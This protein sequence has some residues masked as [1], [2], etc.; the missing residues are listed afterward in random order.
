MSNHPKLK[1]GGKKMERAKIVEWVQKLMTKAADPAATEAERDSIQ[2]KTEQLMAKYKVSMMEATTP[3]KIK[4]HKMTREDVKFVVPGRSFWGFSLAASI[5]PIFECDVV[6]TSGTKKM[7]FL[8]YPEDVLTCVHFFRTFQMQI[9]FAVDA[10]DYTT[11]KEKSSYAWGMVKRI[12]E[13]MNRAYERVKEIIPVETKA[14]IVL[15]EEEVEKFTESLFGK[16]S[17]GAKSKAKV[18]ADAFHN[19]YNDGANVNISHRGR[20]KVEKE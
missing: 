4:N 6:R 2:A 11:I 16:I 5:A 20:R 10:T 13:R 1:S 19:G 7:S 17:K 12:T 8:G 9:I 3:E 18:D 14:L 15:K